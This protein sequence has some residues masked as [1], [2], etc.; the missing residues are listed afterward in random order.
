MQDG[1]IVQR[2]RHEEL[3]ARPGLY[4]DLWQAGEKRP[5]E[6]KA[7]ETKA[8]ETMAPETMAAEGKAS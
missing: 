8:P 7:P 6:T 4:R 1:R 5:P 3:L 2:G